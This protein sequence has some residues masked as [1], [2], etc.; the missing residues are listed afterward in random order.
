VIDTEQLNNS[1]PNILS[2]NNKKVNEKKDI[3]K[4]QTKPS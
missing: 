1:H 3:N 2:A 4:K